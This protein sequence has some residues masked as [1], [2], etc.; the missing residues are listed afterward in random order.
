MKFA[1]RLVVGLPERWSLS[2]DVQSSLKQL[3]HSL[4]CVA[5]IASSLKARQI[6]Q[7]VSALESLSFWQ[8]PDSVPLLHTF[9]HIG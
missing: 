7:I 9:S 1:F 2:A 3:N 6:F 5:P 4:I 8:K